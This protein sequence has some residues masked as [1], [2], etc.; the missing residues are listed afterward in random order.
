MMKI[1]VVHNLPDGGA[2]RTLFEILKILH[3]K[4]KI[5]LY[6]L[7]TTQKSQY[8][9]HKVVNKHLVFDYQYPE[10]F[11][12]SVISIYWKLP[13]V[14]KKMA[15]KINADN[16]DV[17]LVFP[18]FLTQAPFILRYLKIPSVYFCPEP[19]REFYEKIPRRAKKLTYSLTSPF[20]LYI[21]KIDYDNTR[22]ADRVLTLSRYNR[23][24]LKKVYGIDSQIIPLGVNTKIFF[25]LNLKKENQVITIG[26]F[27]LLKG[28]DFI[29]RCLSLIP[30][31]IRPKLIIAG[32]EGSDKLY[33]R[34]L[35]KK[36]DVNLEIIGSP[37][38][39]ELNRLYN[40]SK[41]LVFA[42]L[43]EPF[44]LVVLEAWA[45]GLK[46]LA[47]KEGGVP[48]LLA[49][50]YLGKMVTRREK[51][52]SR[53][54]VRELKLDED[55]NAPMLR[56]QYVVDNWEWPSSASKLENYLYLT[57]YPKK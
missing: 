44:G 42:A 49:E 9:F 45:S 16:Y 17:A 43:Y 2:K 20:R 4:H 38:D 39:I 53:V 7:T 55:K 12:L 3:K 23:A 40:K 22:G 30:I 11:P 33:F 1:A 57:A 48:E 32:R 10:H 19:K 6:S 15:E 34:K 47:V 37:T 14:Y 8:N 18:C 50:E 51:D 56:R 25:P 27:T 29:I 24:Y 41:L 52:F 5:D 28:H 46:L 26:N 13:Q 54:L 21:K 36:L 35:A 31:N